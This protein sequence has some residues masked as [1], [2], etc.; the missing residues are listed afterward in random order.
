MANLSKRDTWKAL[1]EPLE[2]YCNNCVY[3]DVRYIDGRWQE[4]CKECIEVAGRGGRDDLHWKW[5]RER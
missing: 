3:S 2:K 5:N 4:P 1:T